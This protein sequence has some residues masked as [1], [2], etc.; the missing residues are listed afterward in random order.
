MNRE[1]LLDRVSLVFDG[2]LARVSLSRAEKYNGLDLP[3]MRALV[4]AAKKIRRNRDIR[5]VIL[6]GEGKAFSAG[7]D[8]AS[9]TRDPLGIVRAFATFGLKKANLFQEVCLCWRDLPVPVITVL[10]GYC[11]GGA[12]QIAL[13]ADFRI[14]T[15]DC[16]LSIMEI[17]WGLIPDM[18]ATVTLRELIP[19]DLARELT[20]TGRI[21]DGSEARAMNL[22]TR[23]SDTPIEEAEQ[24]ARQIAARS[25][26][27]VSAAKSLFRKTWFASERKALRTE[28]RL[29]LSLL[30]G[31]NRARAMQANKDDK[32]PEFLP[33]SRDY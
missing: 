17:K 32:A 27:G 18:S 2:P 23:V 16:Q 10:H 8:F 7:L 14:S 30:T 20:M 15:P 29:Q 25:P 21:F 26:D 1:L 12:L 4:M 22:V 6:D 13:A 31:N 24:L 3:M 5:V 28:R 9:V 11:Y 19:M 33:R